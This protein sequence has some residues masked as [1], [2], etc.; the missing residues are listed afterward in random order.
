MA[1]YG[2]TS[3]QVDGTGTINLASKGFKSSEEADHFLV[4]ERA[5]E[6]N[7]LD[8]MEQHLKGVTRG[9][10]W[11]HVIAALRCIASSLN[12]LHQRQLIH[13]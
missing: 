6:G 3:L 2:I 1:F 12:E 5:S 4:F 8:F 11:F 10:S 9:E 13:G 7:L